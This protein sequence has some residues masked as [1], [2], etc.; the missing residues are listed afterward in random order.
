MTNESAR[1]DDL[2][3][4]AHHTAV[5]VQDFEAA[6]D[7]F[8]GV[9][10]FRVEGEMD[11]RTDVAPVVGLP[12][13]VI[14]WGMLVRGAYRVEL[15]KYYAPAGRTEPVRQC[16]NGY[17]HMA[18]EVSDV[19]AAYRRLIAA[20][21]RTLSP[22]TELRGGITKAVYVLAP[23]NNVTELIEFRKPNISS[24]RN[25]ATAER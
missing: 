14:R 22:P 6:R 19:D 10:G 12:D 17:T 11:R 16:D 4:C 18:F 25:P 2:I 24:V 23:E 3:V 15:F 5:C 21:Y 13:A 1:I 7:F 8:T 20:G 9:L